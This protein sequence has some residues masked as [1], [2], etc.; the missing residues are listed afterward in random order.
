MRKVYA[1]NIVQMLLDEARGRRWRG[2]QLEGY[3]GAD[4]EGGIDLAPNPF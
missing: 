1:S 4:I 3:S 2:H